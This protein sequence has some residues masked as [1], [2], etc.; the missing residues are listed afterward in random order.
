MTGEADPGLRARKRQ[1]TRAKVTAA[2]MKLFLRNGFD[3]VTIDDIA[4]AADISSR[5]FFNHFASKEDVAIAWQDES[6]T[7]LAEEV[8]KRPAGETPLEAAANALINLVT[9]YDPKEVQALAAFAFQT[10]ALK[11]REAAKYQAMEQGLFAALKQRSGRSADELELRIVSAVAIS[12]LR[13]SSDYW[14]G[15]KRRE[16]AQAYGAR[17]FETLHRAVIGMRAK[18]GSVP[19]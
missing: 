13:I 1:Q 11:S 3:N 9:R 8:L 4:A 6:G 12:L 19:G 2:A 18:P 5:S 15:P 16:T 10:P 14:L 17:V 7:M